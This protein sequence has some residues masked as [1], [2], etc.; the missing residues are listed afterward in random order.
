MDD[1]Q[2]LSVID[3]IGATTSRTEK[4]KLLG[5]L[6]ADDLGRF[7]L[8][9]TYNPFVTYGITAAP[10]ESNGMTCL[11]FKISLIK[12][13]LTRLASRELTGMAAEREIAEVMSVL[14]KE[15]A[16]LLYLILSKDL[17]CGIAET[18]INTVVPGLIPVF[19][20]MRAYHYEVG[21]VKR[22]PQKGEYKLDGNRNSF[23]CKDGNG[24]F[25]TRSGK[26]VPA[27]DFMVDD[28]LKTAKKVWSITES[29]SLKATLSQDGGATFNY[30]LDGEAMMGLFADTGALRRKDVDAVGA[31]LHLYDIMSLPDFDAVGSQGPVLED[32]RTALTEFVRVAKDIGN[33]VIQI[34][35]QFFLNDDEAV[36][37]FFEK[38]RAKTLASYLAR[39]D[40]EREA[41]LLKTTID[42]A[43]GKPKVLEGAMIKDPKGLYDKKKS[44]GW[45]KMKAEETEDLRIV[46]VFGGKPDTKY[47]SCLGGV[48]VDRQGVSVRI[49]GGFSDEERVELWK[50][51]ERDAAALGIDPNVGFKGVILTGAEISEHVTELLARLIEV[52]FHEVTPDGSLR[53]P[54]YVRFRDDKDGEVDND[55]A[56]AA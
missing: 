24:G 44:Y 10:N 43:T 40:A 34:V 18:T 52:E 16:R 5:L 11:P 36:Q 13:I 56:A 22:W 37:A 7:I 27:L 29:D 26:R 35:P 55:V 23:I 33:A 49:G 25:F 45:M 51:W 28:I 38:A 12:P 3:D 4:T 39:G 54:R 14:S 2:I 9:W 48:I 47:E 17:K 19:S 20:V 8:E 1:Y 15:G 42:K 50:L 41:E 6:A 53:H 46:G 31:E 21:K 32:R 30:M